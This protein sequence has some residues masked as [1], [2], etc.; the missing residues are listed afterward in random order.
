LKSDVKIISVVTGSSGGIG[1]AVASRLLERGDRVIGIDMRQG[2]LKNHEIAFKNLQIDSEETAETIL[3][4]IKDEEGRIDN[5]INCAGIIGTRGNLWELSSNEFKD[6]L[7]NN[8]FSTFWMCKYVA[9]IMIQQRYGRIVNFG[10]IAGKDGSAK[11]SQY[12]SSKAAIIALTK[13][14]GKE[15]AL[16]DDVLCNCVAPAAVET[17]ALLALSAEEQASHLAKIPMRRFCQPSEVAEL[18][19]WLSSPACSF[20]TGAVFDI[21]GGR[22]TY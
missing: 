12:A 19:A 17:A 7:I 1:S 22:A 3:K 2:D 5:L 6:I 16:Y 20:S 15:L 14:L 11:S 9:K 18:V 13:A 8:L 10:A 4:E 21:S